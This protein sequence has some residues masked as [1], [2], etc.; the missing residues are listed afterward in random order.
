MSQGSFHSDRKQKRSSEKEDLFFDYPLHSIWEK[1]EKS[2]Y[3][4]EWGR[5]A[6]E[7]VGRTCVVAGDPVGASLKNKV[8]AFENFKRWADSKNLNVCGYYFSEEFSSMVPM[9]SHKAGVSLLLDLKDWSLKGSA[10]E[11][12]R[13]ALIKGQK[14]QLKVMEIFPETLLEW[15]P[16]LLQFSRDWRR[17]KG[18]FQIQFLLSPL[19]LSFRNLH[20]GERLFV[21]I[22]RGE[23]DA[24]VSVTP[25]GDKKWYVDQLLQHPS[26][27]RFALD[28]LLVQVIQKLKSEGANALSLGFC[29]GIIHRSETLVERA[30]QVWGRLKI[31]YSPKGLYNFKRKYSSCELNRYLLL[32]PK[33]SMTG[34][35]LNMERV[36]MS[37]T[38]R[39]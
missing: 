32:D 4:D 36:T 35:L 14:Q 15:E 9:K 27:D 18:L 19:S 3:S 16:V 1:S 2:I 7:K 34:Q 6:Y 25:W 22:R 39:H 21:C 29:P 8:M 33:S 11:E 5:L 13:R 24:V 26:G 23:L 37:L 10:S 31:F 20:A 12:A 30:L 38:R 17:S 28:Y